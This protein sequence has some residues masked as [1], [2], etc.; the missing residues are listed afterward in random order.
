MASKARD[1]SRRGHRAMAS[2]MTEDS[3]TKAH[4]GLG[5]VDNDSTATIRS[6]TTASD[7]GLGNVT[8]ESKATMFTSPTFTGTTNLA[9]PTYIAG[10]SASQNAKVN[11]SNSYHKRITQSTYTGASGGTYT[12]MMFGRHWWGTGNMHIHIHETWYGPNASYGHF[13]VHGHTRSGNPSIH[14]VSNTG[15]P[16]P[17]PTNYNGTYERCQIAFSHGSYYRYT[18]VCENYES[19]Y[20][21]SDSD[22]GHNGPSGGANS[23]HMY[24]STEYI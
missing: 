6:G 24:N 1:L 21:T 17:F 5:N 15:A 2:A 7:V 13:L 12:I 18:I 8:N 14:T 19:G 9:S 16:V 11:D 4:V 22:V 3:I 23:W 10:R 20:C